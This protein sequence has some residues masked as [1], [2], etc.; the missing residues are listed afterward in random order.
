MFDVRPAAVFLFGG[1]LL[2]AQKFG[3]GH[4]L[5]APLATSMQDNGELIVVMLFVFD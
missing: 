5:P 3:G 4:G 1:P 2:K